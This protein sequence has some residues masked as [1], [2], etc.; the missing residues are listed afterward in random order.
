MKQEIRY[1]G[2]TGGLSDHESAD[3]E[4]AAALNLVPE[5]G[6]LRVVEQPSVICEMPDGFTVAYVHKTASYEH[7]I[8]LQERTN[9]LYW[10]DV[11]EVQ[12][13][14][15]VVTGDEILYVLG[16][17]FGNAHNPLDPN[18][19][20]PEHQD[21]GRSIHCFEEPITGINAIGNTIEVLTDGDGMHYV[22]WSGESQTYNYKGTH[23]PELP[24]SFGLQGEVVRN[25]PRWWDTYIEKS[26]LPEAG[27][28]IDF[29]L[30]AFDGGSEPL[31]AE[32]NKFIR[33]EIVEKGKFVFPFLVRYA[34]RLYNGDI[35]MHSSPVLMV[36]NSFLAPQV[37][38][39]GWH[40]VQDAGSGD[41]YVDELRTRLG[42]IRY[43]LDYQCLGEQ[44]KEELQEWSDI[45]KSVD[46]FISAPIY[47]YKQSGE[48]ETMVN[49]Q[50]SMF[51]YSLAKVPVTGSDA[52]KRHDTAEVVYV[53][54]DPTAHFDYG[55]NGGYQLL[56]PK[57]TEGEINKAICDCSNFYLLKSIEVN[58]IALERTKIEIE[59]DYLAALTSRERM[60]GDYDSHDTLLP[61]RMHTYNNRLILTGLDKRLGKPVD[62]S[63][64]A[65]YQNGSLNETDVYVLLKK[66]TG[67]FVVKT[68]VSEMGNGLPFEYFFY[69]D[70]DAY[71]AIFH[72]GI[73]YGMQEMRRHDFLHGAYCGKGV[74]SHLM[75][76]VEV[77]HEAPEVSEDPIVSVQNKLYMSE[78]NNP[79]IFPVGNTKTVGTGIIMSICT[80]A[81][82]LSPGQF[83]DFPV[84]AFCSDGIWSMAVNKEDGTLYPAQPITGDVCTNVDSITPLDGSVLFITD[85]GI[86]N[87]A[88]NEAVCI[89]DVI[90]TDVPFGGTELSHWADLVPFDYQ[91]VPFMDYLKD[92]RM[93]YDYMHQRVVVF[94]AAHRY[95]YLLSL[96][97]KLWGM[98]YSTLEKKINSYPDSKAMAVGGKLVTLSRR[99]VGDEVEALMV[100]R[101]LKLTE[102]D[103]LKSMKTV[104][105]RGYFERGDVK[106]VLYGSQDLYHW[107]LIDSSKTEEIRNM[108]GSAYKYFRIAAKV[109]M[110]VGKTL[111][112]A[113]VEIEPRY[114][115]KIK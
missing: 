112:G 90:A 56:L 92:S 27:G 85:R 99:V 26:S 25:G 57:Y 23:L 2:Y 48:I 69:P 102:G 9:T 5:D 83:G 4:L 12:R 97:S 45:V 111:Y 7:Y 53:D 63:A 107:Y 54:D 113:T 38:V 100:T 44:Y 1:T 62:T 75:I 65:C 22:M 64:Y 13:D 31:I 77:L 49:W 78:V 6:A 21:S 32:A 80:A 89:S 58:N 101:P 37:S 42:A 67:V 60:T 8:L 19:R 61:S 66:D 36:T 34:Y 93:I 15:E 3:G 33:E 106:T 18:W 39:I 114:L 51:G 68:K 41:D 87:I 104:L 109:K 14:G 46:I 24:L 11:S 17:N 73:Y 28:S 84:Y 52:Y 96:K 82:P 110:P 95:A 55:I 30:L 88:G 50:A 86:M 79:F 71:Q 115:A 70:P 94:N 40:I 76:P 10:V 20:P 103:V 43:D 72:R 81:K 91:P 108:C 29:S 35:T 74:G 47:T 59:E 98:M 105:Q 16:L